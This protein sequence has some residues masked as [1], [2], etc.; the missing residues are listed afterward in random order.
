MNMASQIAHRMDRQRRF[1]KPPRL[2]KLVA[3]ALE[4]QVGASEA[5]L[6]R[7]PR[8]T[9]VSSQP[10][11]YSSH[12]QRWTSRST[13][14][15]NMTLMLSLR[16][17]LPQCVMSP[18]AAAGGSAVGVFCPMACCVVH[19]VIHHLALQLT[20]VDQSWLPAVLAVRPLLTLPMR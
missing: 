15:I 13:S 2:F 11:P 14:M 18:L 7:S 17:R 16:L 5:G 19:H 1:N 10:G 9:N 3:T 6:A 8:H 20:A 4:S 12:L